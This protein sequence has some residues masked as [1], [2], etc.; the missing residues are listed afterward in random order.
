MDLASIR[1]RVEA[2]TGFTEGPWRYRPN[3]FYDWGEVRNAKNFRICHAR[4]PHCMSDEFLSAC[5]RSGRDPWEDTAR[6]IAAAPDLHADV[7]TL[8]DALA[9]AEA[10]E[11]AAVEAA[12]CDDREGLEAIIDQMAAAMADRLIARNR[13]ADQ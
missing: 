5:W 12:A 10:R 11:R 2:L 13:D 6:L 9:A 8:L 4:Y 7:L 3:E 1:E